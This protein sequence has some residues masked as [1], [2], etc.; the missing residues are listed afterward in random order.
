MEVQEAT[1]VKR[2]LTAEQKR[3]MAEGRRRAIEERN[4][5]RSLAK[6]VAAAA[7]LAKPQP[8]GDPLEGLTFQDCP[9][10]CTPECCVISGRR[11]VM[12]LDETRNAKTGEM[13]QTRVEGYTTYCAHPNKAGLSARDKMDMDVKRTYERAK[14]V[15]KKLADDLKAE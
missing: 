10:A 3:A 12:H 6:S 7:P 5:R 15:L 2:T 8:A 9:N 13:D 1:H 11:K 4:T 14:K